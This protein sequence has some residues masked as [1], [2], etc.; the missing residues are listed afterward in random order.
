MTTRKQAEGL[1]PF[2]RMRARGDFLRCQAKGVRHHSRHML[3]VHLPNGSSVDRLG[4]VVTKKTGNAVVR[5]RWKRVVRERFRKLSGE[6]TN[7][8]DWVVT[9]KR[10]V[11]GP[12]PNEIPG[13]LT[14]LWKKALR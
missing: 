11:Q 8:H 2:A 7:R 4:L 9:V 3:L 12:P 6:L 10:S 13:E 1:P 14:R 5:N